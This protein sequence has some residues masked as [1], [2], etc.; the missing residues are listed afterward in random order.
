M[1]TQNQTQKRKLAFWKEYGSQNYRRLMKMGKL[2]GLGMS[3]IVYLDK[4]TI[5]ILISD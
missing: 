1:S 3:K 5:E 2:F 4:K